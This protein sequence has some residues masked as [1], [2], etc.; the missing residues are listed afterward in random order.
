MGAERSLLGAILL[1]NDLM[2]EVFGLVTKDD[3]FEPANSEIFILLRDQIEANRAATPQTI[4]ADMAQDRD[5]G[6]IRAS[7]YLTLLYTE[8]APTRDFAKQLAV[9]IA[10][11]A[12]KR[13]YWN[14]CHNGLEDVE[15]AAPSTSG[16]TIIERAVASLMTRQVNQKDLGIKSI[17]EFADDVLQGVDDALKSDKDVGLEVGLAALQNLTGT[18]LP[19]RLYTIAGN[20]GSGKSALAGQILM[21]VSGAK[22]ARRSFWVQSEMQ[23]A[24]VASRAM[25]MLTG[26]PGNRIERAELNDAEISALYD[27]RDALRNYTIRIDATTSPTVQKIRGR[28]TVMKRTTGLDLI[29]VDHLHYIAK[30]EA[31]MT[32]IEAI[33]YNMR[34]LKT[35]AKDLKV[36]VIVLMPLKSSYNADS[37]KLRRP[38]MGDLTH[39]AAIDHNSDAIVFVHRP[40]YILKRTE[41]MKGTDE[42]VRWQSDMDVWK[43][44]AELI[45]PKRRDADLG[46]IQRIG[47]D[48]RRM[49]FYDNPSLIS[50]DDTVRTLV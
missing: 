31:K 6:G 35:M 4:L 41:P 23:G 28:A 32:D 8:R 19:G 13:W 29:V 18:L 30:P 26:I 48:G 9:L 25:S 50:H 44:L 34:E 49:R 21:H 15:S 11:L 27:A 1:D 45:G 17:A 46:E 38:N 42:Y 14:F 37:G 47:F 39:P 7:E 24:E 40:E 16:L 10:D 22:S 36:P 12:L 43:G 2:W 5:I 20:P 33:P 3:F